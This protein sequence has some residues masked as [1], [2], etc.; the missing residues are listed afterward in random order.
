VRRGPSARR[1]RRK[2]APGWR[3]RASLG[4]DPNRLNAL[5]GAGQAAE[6]LDQAQVAAG[7]YRTLLK[8]CPAPSGRASQALQHAFTIARTRARG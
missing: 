4:S 3:T 5:L 2:C 7:Y 8:T 1:C 6:L